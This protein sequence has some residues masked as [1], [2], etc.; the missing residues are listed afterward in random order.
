MDKLNEV[1][2]KIEATLPIDEQDLKVI[3]DNRG[4]VPHDALVKLGLAPAVKVKEP[5][6]VTPEPTVVETP[7]KGRKSTK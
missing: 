7:K 5:V 2:R 4:S 3:S 6:A 1:L